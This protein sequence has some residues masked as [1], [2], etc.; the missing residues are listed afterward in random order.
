M[1]VQALRGV[2]CLAIAACH[3][4]LLALKQEQKDRRESGSFAT[5]PC[6]VLLAM[7]VNGKVTCLERSLNAG[8]KGFAAGIDLD[9]AVCGRPSR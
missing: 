8:S 2:I 1:D 5:G 4:R 7:R 3:R 6:L 9:G